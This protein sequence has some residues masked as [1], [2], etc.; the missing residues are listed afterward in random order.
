MIRLATVFSGIGAIEHA[1]KRQE[2]PHEMVYACDIDKFVKKSYFANYPIREDQWHDDVTKIDGS[3]YTGK[4]DLFV[5]GSPCQSFSTMGKLGGFEDTRGTL[6]FEYARLV[7]EMQPKVFIYENVKGLFTHD[8]GK[9]WEVVRNTFEELGYDFTYT[10]MNSKDY[11][12]PQSRPR[13]FVVGFRKDLLGS[14]ERFE[15][16]EKEEL[17]YIG[18]D[19]LEDSGMTQ[20]AIDRGF[21]QIDRVEDKY[22]FSDKMQSWVMT[23]GTKGFHVDPALDRPILKTIL[24]TCYK[25]HRSGIDNYW[26]RPDNGLIRKMT[27]REHLRL[28][29]YSDWFNIDVSNTQLMKQAGN[30]IVVDVIEKILQAILVAVPEFKEE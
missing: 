6:F 18:H 22:T 10:L 30:S 17:K 20:A 15:F 11:G 4:V 2:V 26:T 13:L 21:T 28:M 24:A 7:K 8:K 12:I 5:G 19:F 29:G 16:P 27:P 14:I 25:M 1:L 23:S 9:T 3:K